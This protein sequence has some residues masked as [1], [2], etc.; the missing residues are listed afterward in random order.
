MKQYTHCL[1]L[2]F[3]G[4]A[5]VAC[6]PTAPA[7]T[8]TSPPKAPPATLLPTAI[9]PETFAGGW[10]ISFEYPFP[11]NFWSVGD[12]RYGFYI[13]CPLLMQESYGG[14]WIW[15]RVTD[16]AIVPVYKMPVYLRLAGLSFGPLAPISMDTIHHEQVTIAVVTLLGLTEED[17]KLATTSP[18]CVILMNWDGVSTQI[19]TPGE[20]FQP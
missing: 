20:P 9:P 12:H 18:D 15:F 13:E 6:S 5:L 1:L 16:E 4:L 8:Q 7:P 14:E 2:W 19:L 3:I 10:A 17:A 11:E